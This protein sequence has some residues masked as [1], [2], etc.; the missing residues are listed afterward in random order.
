MVFVSL[1]AKPPGLL[2]ENLGGYYFL[3]GFRAVARVYESEHSIHSKPVFTLRGEAVEEEDNA[4]YANKWQHNVSSHSQFT[5][6]LFVNT[7]PTINAIIATMAL[8]R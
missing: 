6:F 4:R 2:A 5:F 1:N 7:N 3:W 8:K